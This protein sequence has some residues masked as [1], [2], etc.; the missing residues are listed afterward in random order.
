MAIV[1]K[2]KCKNCPYD[3]IGGTE[4]GNAIQFDE[5]VRKA[6]SHANREDHVLEFTGTVK[7]E[8]KSFPVGQRVRIKSVVDKYPIGIFTVGEV[9]TVT[10]SDGYHIRVKLDQ[11]HDSLTDWHNE[12]WFDAD[13][14]VHAEEWVASEYLEAI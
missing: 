1:I 5:L 2:V 7:P 6:Q 12:L 14:N 13:E 11:H 8:G 9:G 10:W 3:R 4:P